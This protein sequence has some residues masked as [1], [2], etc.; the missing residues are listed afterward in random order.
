MAASTT[1]TN[2]QLEW[3]EVASRK[4]SERNDLVKAWDPLYDRRKKLASNNVQAWPETSGEL[5]PRELEITNSIPSSLITKLAS[6]ELTAE[7]TLRAFVKRTVIA[8]HLTNPL[9]EIMFDWG[10]E[11][12]RAL[13]RYWNEFGQPVGP[14]HGLPISLKDLINIKGTETTMGYVAWVGNVP[15][16]N[17]TVVD[18]LSKGGSV[19]YCKTN[20][21]QTLMSGECFNYLF[22][23]TTSPWNTNTSAG[24]SSGGEGSLVAL[25]GSPIGVGSD[26]AGS[27]NTPAQHNGIYGLCPSTQRLPLHGPDNAFQNLIVNGVAGPLSRSIDGLEVYVKGVLSMKPWE[28]DST[29]VKLPWDQG[30]YKEYAGTGR[31]LC[32]GIIN[33]DGVVTPHPPIQRGIR[34]TAKAL[35]AAG[36]YVVETPTFLETVA[37]SFEKS[38][39]DVLNACGDEEIKRILSTY[40]EPVSPEIVLPGPKE[41]LDT[42]QFLAAAN[43]ILRL[44]QKYMVKWMQTA[45]TS[46]TG[47]PIDA[48]I[49]PSGGHVA[50]PHGTMGYLLYEAISNLLDWTCATIPVGFVDQTVDQMPQ[51]GKFIP[52]SEEDEANWVECK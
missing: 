39:M 11:R 33:N 5:T 27:I 43:K 38:L 4:R 21:P 3:R 32:F 52:L 41:K 24:G 30:E 50:P 48:F 26:I 15:Q 17:D 28:F 14:F 20:V 19:F 51:D 6:G 42:P 31:K 10:L 44:R 34:D 2:Q 13:D 23:R 16:S 25:G 18:I 12:A 9:T 45:Q 22:G 40:N 1:E 46:P 29:C 35:R 47:R 37:D 7:E 8:H 49:L 36:H